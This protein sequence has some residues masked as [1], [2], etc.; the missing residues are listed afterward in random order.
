MLI[1]NAFKCTYSDCIFPAMITLVITFV[2][3]IIVHVYIYYAMV[4][5]ARRRYGNAPLPPVYDIDLPP[6]KK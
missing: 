5:A 3:L 2:L 1:E 4:S 6:T